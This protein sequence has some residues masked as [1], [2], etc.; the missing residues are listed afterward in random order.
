MAKEATVWKY[1]RAALL[2]T[3]PLLAG[4][5]AGTLV[6]SSW[7]APSAHA[8]LVRASAS[9][10]RPT[11][12]VGV[13]DSFMSGEGAGN[14]DEDSDRPRNH[15]HRSPNAALRQADL[16]G[17]STAINLA[18]SGAK[19]DNVRLG[20][21]RR[22]GEPPQLE[23]LGTVARRYQIRAIVVT[24]GTNDI[25]FLRMVLDCSMA[26]F[27]VVAPCSTR[28]SEQLPRR[29]AVLRPRL[30]DVLAQTRTVMREAGYGDHAYQLIL[31]SYTSPVGRSARYNALDRTFHG[32][33]YRDEDLRWAHDTA[34]PMT[35][36]AMRMAARDVPGVR[37]LNLAAAFDGREICSPGLTHE[38]EWMWGVWVDLDAIRRG[39]GQN[40]VAQSMHPKA[41]GHRMVSRCLERFYALP[42]REARCTRASDGAARLSPL[43]R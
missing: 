33:P 7:T 34:I 31:Q 9:D 12:V 32:C 8:A 16:P 35:A 43:T 42:G 25:P 19:L 26:H 21:T 40:L 30:A 13:G 23:A 15:C 27:G 17:I 28:W 18:C 29:L 2:T 37:F 24:V 4:V 20:G 36:G 11:A 3:S 1:R 5:V 6:V 41:A 22:F 14:Y 39:I 38:E 10:T